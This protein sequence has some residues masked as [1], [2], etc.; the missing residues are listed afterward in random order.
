M[1]APTPAFGLGGT[2]APVQTMAL[3]TPSIHT[4]PSISRLFALSV[5]CRCTFTML[6][7]MEFITAMLTLF[8][9]YIRD[10]PDTLTVATALFSSLSA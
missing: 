4:W 2:S 3:P 6:V 1:E 8:Q 10:W 7:T 9:R 5:V